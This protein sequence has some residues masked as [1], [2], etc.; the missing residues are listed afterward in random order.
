MLLYYMFCS[1][2]IPMV[3][4]SL[5]LDPQLIYV[6]L[7][8]AHNGKTQ[9]EFGWWMVVWNGYVVTIYCELDYPRRSLGSGGALWG[10]PTPKLDHPSQI[11]VAHFSLFFDVFPPPRKNVRTP[12][13]SPSVHFFG[14]ALSGHVMIRESLACPW[15]PPLIGSGWFLEYEL[16][17]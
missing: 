9:K 1:G 4:G 14:L 8:I 2:G 13:L 16:L 10:V 17:F 12:S 3:L 15:V 6:L 11:L 5:G 7:D